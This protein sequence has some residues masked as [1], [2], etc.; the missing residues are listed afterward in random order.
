MAMPRGVGFDILPAF[1][2]WGRLL[3]FLRHVV[4]VVVVLLLPLRQL[5]HRPFF[6][7]PS[8]LGTIGTMQNRTI[9]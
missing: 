2:L 5:H 1:R 9:Q 7:F 6:V 8:F 4:V 3:L